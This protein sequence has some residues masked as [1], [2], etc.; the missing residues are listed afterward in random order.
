MSHET[1]LR[2]NPIQKNILVSI[3]NLIL[4]REEEININKNISINAHAISKESGHDFKTC[5]KYLKKLKDI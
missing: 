4:R 2:I 3:A 1:I 5:K